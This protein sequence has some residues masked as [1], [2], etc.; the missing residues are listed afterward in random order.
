MFI[1]LQL[2]GDACPPVYGESKFY[3]KKIR[4]ALDAIKVQTEIIEECLNEIAKNEEK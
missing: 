2:H 3:S 1:K 4:K